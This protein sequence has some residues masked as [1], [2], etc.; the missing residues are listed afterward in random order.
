MT[1]SQSASS[2]LYGVIFIRIWFKCDK[3][4]IDAQATQWNG[5]ERKKT[6][7]ADVKEAELFWLWQ[8]PIT[9]SKEAD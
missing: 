5:A 6:E 4:L 7:I 3:I 2:G 1:E 8:N 9:H